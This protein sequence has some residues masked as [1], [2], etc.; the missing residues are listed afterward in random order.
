VSLSLILESSGETDF[1]LYPEDHDVLLILVLLGRDVDQ[2]RMNSAGK[3]A[4]DL[5]TQQPEMPLNLRAEKVVENFALGSLSSF[6]VPPLLG[7][8]VL[9]PAIQLTLI[10]K[11]CELYGQKFVVNA[12]KAKIG[13]FLS[14]LLMLST[15]DSFGM[16][17]RYIP[18]IGTSWRRI[19][20]ALIGSASTY[21]IGKVFIL[22]FDSGG[23]LLNLNP[24]RLRTYYFEQLEK[25]RLDHKQWLVAQK[26]G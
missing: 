1:N 8:W 15:T 23:A 20:T 17:L 19:S 24:E 13:I 2:H 11:L 6:L 3:H 26:T 25:A 21:A 16:V 7:E 14:W 5:T 10:H 12:A 9:L 4:M 22:H 18:V